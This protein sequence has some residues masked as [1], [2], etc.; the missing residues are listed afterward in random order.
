MEKMKLLS[1]IGNRPQFV[2]LAPMLKSISEHNAAAPDRKLLHKIVHTGQHY[3]V[4]MNR[5]LFDDL[6]LPRPDFYLGV[7]SGTQ[8]WQTG[9]MLAR[10]ERVLIDENPDVVLVYGDTNST[11]AGALASAKMRASLVH[12]EAGL[13]SYNYNMP[14]ETNRVLTD[15]CSDI[16]LCPTAN[17]VS[18]LRKEGFVE[19]VNEG[20]IIAIEDINFDIRKERPPIVVNV[21]D[22]MYDSLLMSECLTNGN[23]QLLKRFSLVPNEYYLVTVHRAENTDNVGRLKSIISALEHIDNRKTIMFP[24]HPRTRKIL[25][26]ERIISMHISGI[27]FTDPVSYNEMLILEKHAA[28]VLTDSGGVQ[29]EAF[30][31]GAPCIVL[32]DETEWVEL[33][34]CGAVRIGGVQGEGI[35]RAMNEF[36]KEY[37]KEHNAQRPLL[38]DGKAAVR[39]VKLLAQLVING[40]E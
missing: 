7:G 34:E 8:G 11:L 19:I 37:L 17:A 22:V 14:E 33:V 32:R 2:K 36:T 13:R 1:V 10:I 27:K 38:G 3:S 12:V 16:L 9:R 18:N 5:M 26:E 35:H 4:K 15:H 23:P 20:E 29:R 40:N 30:L 28:A 21:G 6:K 31:L 24:L 25:E 39:I